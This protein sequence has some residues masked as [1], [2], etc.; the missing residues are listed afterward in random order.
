MTDLTPITALGGTAP[1]VLGAARLTLSE[2]PELALASLALGRGAEPPAPEGL[3]LPGPGGLSVQGAL[4]AFWTGPDQW[5]VE[6][7]DLAETDFAARLQQAAPGA[8]VTEQTDGWACFE[9]AGEAAQIEALAERLVNLPRDAY[10]PGRASR[11]A[12]HHMGVFLL[13]RSPDRLA[14]WGMRSAAGSLWHAL[15]DTM[16]RMEALHD[17]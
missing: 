11:T 5:M 9:I 16:A 7:A 13:R 1:R 15:S 3:A 10:A 2:R 8:A 17:S 12:L 4:A 6:G 14:V